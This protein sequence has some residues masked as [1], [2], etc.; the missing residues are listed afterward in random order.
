MPLQGSLRVGWEDEFAAKGGSS[1]SGRYYGNNPDDP[2]T[3]EGTEILTMGTE[4]LIEDPVEFALRDP[5]YFAFVV[6]VLQNRPA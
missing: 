3:A 6:T 1:Y 5:E 4:R 2:E